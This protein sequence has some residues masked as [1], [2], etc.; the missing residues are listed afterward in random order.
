VAPYG[1]RPIP[2]APAPSALA[3]TDCSAADCTSSVSAELHA[4]GYCVLLSTTSGTALASSAVA[5]TYTW[6]MPSAWPMTGMRVAALIDLTS[7][8]EPRGITSCRRRE[9]QGVGGK[10]LAEGAASARAQHLFALA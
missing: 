3:L 9:E 10:H 6:Q 4:A 7:A 5:S 2:A 8:L 1:L